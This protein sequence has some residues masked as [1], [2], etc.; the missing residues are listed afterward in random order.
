MFT[1]AAVV[2]SGG[3]Q[4]PVRVLLDSAA[5]TSLV[6]EEAVRW[7]G[8]KCCAADKLTL[9]GITEGLSRADR[10]AELTLTAADGSFSLDMAAYVAPKITSAKVMTPASHFISSAKTK[11]INL[12]KP[13]Q[14]QQTVDIL[15]DQ[16]WL[17]PFPT[18]KV[19]P[20]GPFT[21]AF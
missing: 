4:V 18:P 17:F 3:Q 14:G 9:T 16:D 13:A 10:L 21:C 15:I 12:A 7:T 2:H 6:T 5:E 20:L 8:V 19:V 11:G 1:I